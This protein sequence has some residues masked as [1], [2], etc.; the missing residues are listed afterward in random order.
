[1]ETWRIGMGM[2]KRMAGRRTS[3][4]QGMNDYLGAGVKA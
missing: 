4:F 1:M 2:T 3:E